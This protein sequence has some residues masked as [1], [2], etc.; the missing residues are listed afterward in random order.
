MFCAGG[1]SSGGS[2]ARVV[3][4][5]AKGAAGS[6]GGAGSEAAARTHGSELSELWI[7]TEINTFVD[8]TR[9]PAQAAQ[10]AEVCHAHAHICIG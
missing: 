7:T 4:P 2:G 3:H 9:N 1:V 5:G 8:M 10:E 6:A